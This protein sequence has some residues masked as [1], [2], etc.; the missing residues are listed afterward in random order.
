MNKKDKAERDRLHYAALQEAAC[1]ILEIARG[2]LIEA[3]DAL[4]ELRALAEAG[5]SRVKVIKNVIK[6]LSKFE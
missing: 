3:E 5:E 1:R 4:R 2:N 6:E